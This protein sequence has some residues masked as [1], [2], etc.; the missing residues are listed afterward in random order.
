MMNSARKG[1]GRIIRNPIA[2]SGLVLA[3]LVL[4]APALA[5]TTAEIYKCTDRSGDVTYQNEKCPAGSQAGRVD[6]FD[7]NWTAS[8]AEKNAEWQ[9]NAADRRV[10]TACRHTG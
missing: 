5:A 3:S 9:R 10:V 6:I 1:R 8:R 7:N 2:R 4:C